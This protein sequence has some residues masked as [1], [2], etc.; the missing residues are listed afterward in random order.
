MNFG[1]VSG[2]GIGVGLSQRM[3][4][5]LLHELSG[6]PGRFVL[7]REGGGEDKSHTLSVP[8]FWGQGWGRVDTWDL[9]SWLGSGHLFLGIPRAVELCQEPWMSA[10]VGRKLLR[11]ACLASCYQENH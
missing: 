3:F 2:K 4:E 7:L 11:I 9:P 8:R 1:K 6:H 5:P 10:F